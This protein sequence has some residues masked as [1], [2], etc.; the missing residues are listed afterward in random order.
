MYRERYSK[1]RIYGDNPVW[2][3]IRAATG[4]KYAWNEKSTYIQKPPYFEGFTLK[5]APHLDFKGMRA[6]ALFGDSV[7]TD[8]ISPAGAFSANTPAGKYLVGK[9][10]K[11]E[12]FNSYGSR[13]GNHHVM[14]RGTFANVRIRNKMADGKE[15]GFTKIMPEGAEATIFEACKKYEERGV[16]LIVF[17][18][19]D[20]GMGSSRDWAAKG[21]S[22]LGVRVVVAKSFERIHRSNLIGM[23][24][25]P[26][27]F[28]EGEDDASLGI[29]GKEIFHLSGFGNGLKPKQEVILE[30]ER[31][32]GK[33]D[34]AVLLSRLDTPIEVDYFLNGGIMPFVLRHQ[35]KNKKGT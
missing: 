6:L 24:V 4:K 9:G 12:H 33:R 20:Y 17:A 1:E 34:K 18:G 35:L 31:Y 14:M 7:T 29:T 21:S 3:E 5:A 13:R 15:G 23:G 10:V 16:P 25:L 26:L 30:I 11:P 22:L 19:K 8:H 27:E 32:G 28:R 2:K